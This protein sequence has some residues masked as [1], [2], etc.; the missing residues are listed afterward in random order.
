MKIHPYKYHGAGNDFLLLDNRRG[1]IAL[2]REQI[3]ALCNRRLGIGA[4]GLM[5][6]ESWDDGDFAMH[7]YNS[8]GLDGP[9]CGN[10]GRCISALF[11]SL[12]PGHGSPL[13]FKAIDGIHTSEILE[14]AGEAPRS[15]L[16]MQVK[17]KMCDITAPDGASPIT[18]FRDGYAIDT[19]C[20]HFV[21]FCSDLEGCPVDTLGRQIRHERRFFP[22]GTNVDFVERC[23]DGL[24]MR[25]YEKGVEAETL[26]C[27]TGAIASALVAFHCGKGGESCSVSTPGGVLKVEFTPCGGGFSDICLTGPATMVFETWVEI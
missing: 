17:L 2:T 12:S 22:K 24:R 27:G 7:Y 19:G 26:S 9:M 25:T 21:V 16:T 3:V 11:S 1:E 18:E 4:D 5:T 23:G 10:G 8:D 13:R 6:L 20:P 14:G 15:G